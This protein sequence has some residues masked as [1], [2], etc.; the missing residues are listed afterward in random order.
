MTRIAKAP[1]GLWIAGLVLVVELVLLLVVGH[2]TL[3]LLQ[4]ASTLLVAALVVLGSRIGWVIALLG[5]I[6]DAVARLGGEQPF[7]ILGLDGVVLVALVL[8]SSLQFVWANR[9]PGRIFWPR[10]LPRPIEGLARLPYGLI[11]WR[12]GFA[13]MV[14][15]ILGGMADIWEEG[16]GRDS[17]VVAVLADAARLMSSVTL[18]AFVVSFCAWLWQRHQEPESAP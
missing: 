10:A 2:L 5:M 12:L 18:V 17:D 9:P 14:L 8:P 13:L 7:W 3:P 6:G 1:V 4:A 11:A 16:S 15:L